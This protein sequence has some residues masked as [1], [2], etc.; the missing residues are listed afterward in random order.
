[1]KMILYKLHLED[2]QIIFLA[3]VSKLCDKMSASH[4]CWWHF[5]Q[6]F[7][8]GSQLNAQLEGWLSQAQSTAGPAR[9]IIAP[10][11]EWKQTLY[12]LLLFHLCFC[13]LKTLSFAGTLAT[14]TAARVPPTPTSRW[15]P[16]SRKCLSCHQRFFKL[17]WSSRNV[18]V[19]RGERGNR[20][21]L[22]FIS[23]RVF[24]LGPSHHV[25]L[26]RCALSPA[27]VYR[28][29]LYDLRID[30]KGKEYNFLPWQD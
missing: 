10:Y 29:P 24:I 13:I 18:R 22:L 20:S 23:R 15:T 28:T 17:S 4:I 5:S 21:A 1:M 19:C 8:L 30:Q 2:I 6:S 3:E 11:V 9:A 12:F 14:L 25:P 26:S 27:E 7:R 16:P